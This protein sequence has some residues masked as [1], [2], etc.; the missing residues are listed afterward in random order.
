MSGL[1]IELY[2]D[3]D[4]NVLIAELVRARGFTAV[5]TVEAGRRGH[6]DPDQLAY[7]VSQRKT[8]LTHNRTDFEALAREYADAGRPHFGILIA[9]RRPPYDLARRLLLL[10]NQITAEEMHDQVLYI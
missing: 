4:V 10:L 5:T 2:L 8:L 1:F 7:A 9:V 3:E 6:S